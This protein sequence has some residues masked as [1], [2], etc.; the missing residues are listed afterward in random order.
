MGGQVTCIPLPR[1][2]PPGPNSLHRYPRLSIY[3][4]ASTAIFI[5]F[6]AI[7]TPSPPHAF[8]IWSIAI[9]SAIYPHI[10]LA[11]AAASIG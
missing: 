8:H 7:S 10:P 3:L 11:E 6:W 5:L 9:S 2:F 4:P 1:F